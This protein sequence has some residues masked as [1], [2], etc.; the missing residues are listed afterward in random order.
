MFLVAS[1]DPN[2]SDSYAPW[3]RGQNKDRKASFAFL[4][5]LENWWTN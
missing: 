4:T 3:S 5:L 1:N 2:L